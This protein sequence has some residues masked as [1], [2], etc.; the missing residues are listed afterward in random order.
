M[1]V[2]KQLQKK[3]KDQYP[4]P[5]LRLWTRVCCN[6]LHESLDDPPGLPQFQSAKKNVCKS[7]TTLSPSKVADTRSNYIEQLHQIKSLNTEGVLSDKEYDEQKDI[8]LE[9][10][11]KLK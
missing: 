5:L 3:H 7:A 11:R 9:T 8:I 1:T 2:L 6:G 10:L 4:V